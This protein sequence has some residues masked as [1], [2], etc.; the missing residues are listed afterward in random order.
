METEL[1]KYMRNMELSL[2]TY[3]NNRNVVWEMDEGLGR[4]EGEMHVDEV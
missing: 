3:E 4:H 2:E 1:G